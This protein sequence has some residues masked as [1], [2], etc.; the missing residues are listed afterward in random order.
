MPP[1]GV[2]LTV[3]LMRILGDT[4]PEHLQLHAASAHHFRAPL[5]LVDNRDADLYLAT[6]NL[7]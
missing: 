3:R 2:K 5:N 1:I 6:L 7:R 4:S